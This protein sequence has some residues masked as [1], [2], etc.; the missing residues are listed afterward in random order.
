[1][2]VAVNITRRTGAFGTARRLSG[3]L[4]FALTIGGWFAKVETPEGKNITLPEPPK[5]AGGPPSAIREHQ[6]ILA[7]YNGAYEDPKLEALVRQTVD[8]LVM[9]SERPD[10]R[11]Q[12][13]VLNSPAINAFALPTGQL[14][15][16]RGLI[17]LAND[18][19]ELAS[20][21]SH[22]MAHVIASHAS[23]R[24]DQARQALIASRVV[25][26]VLSDPSVRALA[27]AK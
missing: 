5:D 2:S 25:S 15:V 22:E 1:M 9:A 16:T 11:Y 20:V 23:M 12:I 19:S 27:L 13:T 8:K 24:E 3:V 21:M 4:A 17:A 26:D 10:Q 18:T 14:Y 7:A 6:R